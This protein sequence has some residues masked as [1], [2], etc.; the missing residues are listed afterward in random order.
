MSKS[1]GKV[2][3][4]WIVILFFI[5]VNY[6]SAKE[7]DNPLNIGISP[8][9]TGM[10][11]ACS[12]VC[13]NVLAI[14]Y[15]PAG[16][17]MIE[18]GQICLIKNRLGQDIEQEFLAIAQPIIEEAKI[19]P[20]FSSSVNY[21]RETTGT[22]TDT[23]IIT[24]AY[25]Y[26]FQKRLSLGTGLKFAQQMLDNQKAN[27]V[28]ADLGLLY[29]HPNNFKLG[30]YAQNLGKEIKF[31]KKSDQL[32]FTYG[33]GLAYPYKGYFLSLGTELKITSLTSTNNDLSVMLGIERW[34]K[35]RVSIRCGYQYQKDNKNDGLNMG[36]G[37]KL[38]N[39]NFDYGYQP[40]KD[41]GDIHQLALI[42][43]FNEKPQ[44]K[45]TPQAEVPLQTTALPPHTEV[46]PMPLTGTE[47][48]IKEQV[49][50]ML[51]LKNKEAP[52][53]NMLPVEKEPVKKKG[54]VKEPELKSKAKK[55]KLK[56]DV[57]PQ[58]NVS[59]QIDSTHKEVA[60]LAESAPL[61]KTASLETGVPLIK[62]EITKEEESQKVAPQVRILRVIQ[63]ANIYKGP[64]VEHDILTV[65]RENTSLIL[66]SDS[67]KWYY[68]VKLPDGQIGWV[69]Y[70]YVE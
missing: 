26:R 60:P 41:L 11:G 39:F 19:S 9:S 48:E 25:A 7:P 45:A 40:D 66:I 15:N 68:K 3:I 35:D 63:E 12:A 4:I 64:G 51:P 38:A 56:S 24:L 65:I 54:K 58:S 10:A 17:A 57:L 30:I 44:K 32:P 14:A 55:I 21:I 43:G 36:L 31:I 23:L 69:S 1:V 37:L 13:N 18:S 33:L 50:E 53:P 16:I 5:S 46:I 62:K 47:K 67:N 2:I 42:I 70:L 59:S 29:Q 6:V 27:G 8:R 34:I 28:L 20:V 49:P 52:E 61:S 22:K